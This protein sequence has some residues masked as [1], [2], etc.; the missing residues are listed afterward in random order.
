[1]F[2]E[3]VDVGDEVLVPVEVVHPAVEPLAVR[4]V[5]LLAEG[6]HVVVGPDPLAAGANSIEKNWPEFR[7]EKPLEFWL[8]IH[9]NKKISKTGS[10][11]MSQNQNGISNHFS[12]QNSS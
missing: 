9:Y 1:M 12:S 4:G 3:G 8:Q 6:D 2:P 10:L 7:L 11:D 5:E